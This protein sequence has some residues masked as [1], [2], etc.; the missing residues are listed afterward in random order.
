MASTLNYV[1]PIII[2][3]ALLTAVASQ[4]AAVTELDEYTDL[5]A[6]GTIPYNITLSNLPENFLNVSNGSIAIPSSN[7]ILY[8]DDL[9]LEIN[10]TWT[11]NTL[12]IWYNYKPENYIS[13]NIK[14]MVAIAILVVILGIILFSLGKGKTTSR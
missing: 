2:F 9:K 4:Y 14:L 13:G 3:V 5:G 10:Q 11:G 6:N 1:L 8:E 12:S 7:Y